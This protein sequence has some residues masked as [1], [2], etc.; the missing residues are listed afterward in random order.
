MVDDPAWNREVE[1]SNLSF[2]NFIKLKKRGK[3]MA[4]NQLHQLLAVEQ[5]R[6][7]RATEIAQETITLFKKKEDHL[8]GVVKTYHPLEEKGEKL[9]P[10]VKRVVTTVATKINYTKEFI[11]SA[12]DAQVSKEETNSSGLARTELI[13]K[14]TSLGELSAVSLLALEQHLQR[15]LGIYR[16]IPT[17][18]PV[19]RWVKNTAEE[20]MYITDVDVRYRTTKAE[21]FKVVVPA[22][23]QHPAQIAKLVKDIQVGTWE[24]I[25]KSGKIT[26]LEKSTLLK[27]VDTLIDAVKRARSKANEVEVKQTKVGKK[28]FDF[29][30]EGIL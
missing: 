25:Y 6:R 16:A 23:E 20:N 21:D 29:I 12:I 2:L 7:G 22:T 19:K 8:D 30:N 18:D 10:E 11:I 26:P 14:G 1:S 28:L 5:D 24:T 17:L 13:V 27:R 15:I 4:K 3:N 9:S